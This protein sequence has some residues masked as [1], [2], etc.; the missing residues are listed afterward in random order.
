MNGPQGYGRMRRGFEALFAVL[1]GHAV[2]K[3]RPG[4]G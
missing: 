2:L 1:L 4:R 3:A